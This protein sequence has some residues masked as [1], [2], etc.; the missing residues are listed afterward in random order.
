MFLGGGLNIY[1]GFYQHVNVKLNG[2]TERQKY[3]GSRMNLGILQVQR[4]GEEPV[5]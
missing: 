3:R 2:M 5:G 4:L 1:F